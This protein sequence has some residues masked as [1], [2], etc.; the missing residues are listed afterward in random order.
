MTSVIEYRVEEMTPQQTQEAAIDVLID[1][2]RAIDR[3]GV[4]R[5]KVRVLKDP[6]GTFLA[7]KTAAEVMVMLDEG[8]ARG[9]SVFLYTYEPDQKLVLFRPGPWQER[10][11]NLCN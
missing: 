8:E 1:L 5:G 9:D 2:G 11:R 6:D 4:R 3:H 7:V 10:I